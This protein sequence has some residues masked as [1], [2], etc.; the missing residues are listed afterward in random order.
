MKFFWVV[1]ISIFVDPPANS[2]ALFW[3]IL[4]TCFVSSRLRFLSFKEKVDSSCSI[5]A[6][7]KISFFY[8]S[9]FN[10]QGNFLMYLL[11]I[12]KLLLIESISLRSSV[13]SILTQPLKSGINNNS[14]K[15]MI[16]EKPF[17]KGFVSPVGVSVTLINFFFS[18]TSFFLRSELR[19]FLF[20]DGSLSNCKFQLSG[21]LI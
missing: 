7:G 16:R 11:S 3:V 13:S 9:N 19:D 18:N 17:W 14:I 4:R 1:L 8:S 20:F 2:P 6:S 15:K 21:F 12:T 5:S 10:C